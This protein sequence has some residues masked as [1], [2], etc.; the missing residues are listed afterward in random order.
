MLMF[1]F[2][3]LRNLKRLYGS[4]NKYIRYTLKK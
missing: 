1:T 4:A 2:D 3:K